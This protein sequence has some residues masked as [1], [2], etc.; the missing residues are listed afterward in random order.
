MRGDRA[1][2]SPGGLSVIV[3]HSAPRTILKIDLSLLTPVTGA[4]TALPLVV[5][6]A[7]SLH[8]STGSSAIA[9]A[10][11]ANLVAVVSLVGAPRLSLRL[12]LLDALLMGLA[13]FIGTITVPLAWLHVVILIPWCFGAGMLVVFGQTQAAIG[14]Q[15]IIA[16]VVLGRFTGS[17]LAAL[18]LSLFVVG[19]ALIEILALV[20]LRLPPTFRHQRNQIAN[21]FETIAELARSDPSRPATDFLSSIDTADVALSAPSLFSRT[22]VQELRAILNQV[23]RIRLELTT[24]AGLRQRLGDDHPQVEVGLTHC[25]D[26]VARALQAIGDALRTPRSSG[27]WSTSVDELR[28]CTERVEARYVDQSTSGLIIAQCVSH[29]N[30]VRGQLRSAG[31]LIAQLNAEQNRRAW[32][33]SVPTF[34]TPNPDKLSM[35][36][37]LLR[38]NFSTDSS[39]FRHAVRLAVVIPFSTMLGSVL[40]LPR[41]YWLPFAVAV[42]LKPDYSTLVKRGLGRVVGTML[43]ATIAAVL[44][45]ELKANLTVTIVLVAVIAW[46]AYS[47]WAASFSVAIGFVTALILI[48]LSISSND[49]LGTALDRLL[50]VSLGGALAVIAY[51]LWP[52]SPRAGVSQAESSL[53]KG[54]GDYLAVVSQLVHATPVPPHDVARFS[55]NVRIAWGKAEAAVGRSIEEPASTR[56][57]PAEGRS[58]MSATM[59]ILRVIHALRMEAERGV[60]IGTLDRYD[61]LIA[62]CLLALERLSQHFGGVPL[63][64]VDDLRARCDLAERQLLDAGVAPSLALNL[65]ELVNAINTAQHLAG[66]E[67]APLEF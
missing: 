39:A 36:F 62:G 20:I 13:V 57:D 16:Y 32:R 28:T 15:A 59:R 11:G 5:M 23:R 41:S 21:A 58:L 2:R 51:L 7:I 46:L 29:L 63:T 52:T 54:L 35:N 25:T 38:E 14:T 43:G 64:S 1:S 60:T 44:A 65:G 30:A 22:D 17:A 33:P 40:G 8:F 42:I 6:L 56:I 66:L 53:F 50:D 24:L 12:A 19:G 61:D 31:T 45:S 55:K 27:S 26:L 9:M 4:I 37:S 67:H 3:A 47:T 34:D 10:V 18:H 49:T 48:L